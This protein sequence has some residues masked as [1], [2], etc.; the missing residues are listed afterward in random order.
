[1]LR[2]APLASTVLL[3]LF[4][5]CVQAEEETFDTHFMI[6]G[7]QGVKTDRFQL[8]GEQPIAGEYELDVYVN[9][10]WRGKYTVNINDNTCLTRAQIQL[11][12][13]NLKALPESSCVPLE[14]AVQGGSYTF[15]ISVFRLDLSVPQAF[16]DE[17]E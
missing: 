16:V 9:Q 13:I 8:S 2:M 15:D 10:Q 11:M 4:A 6:G 7:M 3:S 1:M 5:G 12:G 14:Q 17:V